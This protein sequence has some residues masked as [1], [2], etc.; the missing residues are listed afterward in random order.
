MADTLAP[1]IKPL[2]ITNNKN[3]SAQQSIRISI[4]DNLSGIKSYRGTLNGKWILMDYDPKN[5]LLEY[6]FDELLNQG[7]NRFSLEVADDAGNKS[8]YNALLTY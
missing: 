4:S 5:K 8:S 2:N 3:I 6:H 7:V 1:V